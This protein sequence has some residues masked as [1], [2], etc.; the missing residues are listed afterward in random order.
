MGTSMSQ[1]RQCCARCCDCCCP[2]G[3]NNHDPSDKYRH[4]KYHSAEYR[5]ASVPEVK[6]QT[7]SEFRASLG[8]VGTDSGESEANTSSSGGGSGKM[9]FKFSQPQAEFRPH[10]QTTTS[11]SEPDPMEGIVTDQP[12]SFRTHSLDFPAAAA[13]RADQAPGIAL[14]DTHPTL[15]YSLYHDIQKGMLTVHL[16]QAFNL[17][18]RRKN[19]PMDSYITLQLQQTVLESRLVKNDLNP[20]FE[21]EFEFSGQPSLPILKKQAL[22]F[23][24]FCVNKYT[25]PDLLGVVR[26]RL[27]EADLFGDTVHKRIEE[28]SAEDAEVKSIGDVLFSLTYLPHLE[29]LRGT[30]LKAANLK[31]QDITG[32][33]DPYVKVHVIH[34]G[35]K[36]HSW[37]SSVRKNTLTPIFNEQF[38]FNLTNMELA[39][40]QLN[41]IVMDY[42]RFSRDDFMGVVKIGG[43][44]SEETGR[45]HW[46][47][48][49]SA[50]NLAISRWH[51]IAP[52]VRERTHGQTL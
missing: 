14:L 36:V 6:S 25:S 20:T 37:R 44:V 28:S 19:K 50:P 24:V 39:S 26:A 2:D 5:S 49:M 8:R 45:T 32:T 15:T 7:P 42:D 21:Q 41:F 17:P 46:E 52:T 9:L 16:K 23:K 30:L 1:I 3:G 29:T 13:S 22:V 34:K 47:E 35:K 33:A 10:P 12:Q 4:V 40:I 38:Q 43:V 48:M 27:E 31:A 18:P 51:P 11:S